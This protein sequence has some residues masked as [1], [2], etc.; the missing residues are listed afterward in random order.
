MSNDSNYTPVNP[1]GVFPN[2][3]FCPKIV[4]LVYDDSLSYYEFLNKLMVKLNEVITFAN[5]INANVDYLRAIVERIQAL[6]E[7]FDERITQNEADIEALQN[8]VNAINGAI[9][10]INSAIDSIGDRVDTL[11]DGLEDLA[12]SVEQEIATAIVPLQT[13]VSALELAVGG[14]ETRLQT[15]EQAAFDPSQVVMSSNPFNFVANVYD[16]QKAGWRI[17]VDGSGSDYD[18]IRWVDEGAYTMGNLNQKS[19][20]L[21]PFKMPQF[22]RGGNECHLIIPNVL[23]YLYNQAV[24]VNLMYNL[25]FYANRYFY[26]QH[27]ANVWVRK[28]GPVS[29]PTLLSDNGYVV[30]N[31]NDDYMIFFDMELVA[32]QETGNYD[33]WL[34]NGRNGKYCTIDQCKFSSIIISQTDFGRVDWWEGAQRYFNALNCYGSN[35][36]ANT[37]RRIAAESTVLK[38]YADDV[39]QEAASLVEENAFEAIFDGTENVFTPSTGV[40]VVN[41]KSC[42]KSVSGLGMW[43]Y[44]DLTVD[45]ANLAD[46]TSKVL[47]SFST[48]PLRGHNITVQIEKANNGCFGSYDSSGNITIMGF[49]TFGDSA[50]VRIMGYISDSAT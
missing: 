14:I 10:N 9:E 41:N 27:G 2:W 13:S 42:Q 6:I 35:S 47:G 7:G 45:V 20:L 34:H 12:E 5:Q 48:H 50:R 36:I 21:T 38:N 25:Y 37:D 39:A 31:V 40:T 1:M 16:C 23:P 18:S 28:V 29:T 49:G 17:V 30:E 32:N 3:I 4:P 44:I 22:E 46:S 43:Q 8:A 19:K 24:N 26:D 11:E 33:L 15:V